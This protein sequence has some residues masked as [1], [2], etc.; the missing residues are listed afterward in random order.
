MELKEHILKYN[1]KNIILKLLEFAEDDRK[2]FKETFQQYVSLNKI[3]KETLKGSRNINFPESLSESVFCLELK[4]G[5]LVEAINSGSYST[6]F[7]CF[8]RVNNKRIQVKCSASDGP[9]S[10]GPRSQYDEIYFIDFKSSGVIDGTYKIYKLDN[11]D[12]DNVKVNKKQK[13]TDQ[14]DLDRR[15]RFNIRNSIIIPKS[16]K[17]IKVGSL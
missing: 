10:F 14:Q 5:K 1:K 7:D 4:C 9:S 2:I 6:S 12:I 3:I 16:I 13:L 15:P 8:N 11:D 17:P